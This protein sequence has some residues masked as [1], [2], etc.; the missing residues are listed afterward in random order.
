MLTL[1]SLLVPFGLDLQK[2]VRLVRHQDRRYDVT[3]LYRAG[4]LDFYQSIQSEAAF[5]DAETLVV[6]IGEAGTHALFVGVY[7]VR[8]VSRGERHKIP[9][10]FM[11][12]EMPTEGH[13]K[14]DLRLDT[15]FQE[16]VGRVVIDWGKGTRKWVQHFKHKD[17]IEV[18][19]RGYVRGFPG[20]LDVLLTYDELVRIVQHPASHREWHLRLGSMAGI[21]LIV[22]TVTGR[23]YVG[24]A[25][26]RAGL[27]G[28]WTDYSRTGHGGNKQLKQLVTARPGA[29]KDFQFAI[30]QTLPTTLTAKEVVAYEKL[31]KQKL[32][33]RAHGLNSN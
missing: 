28:R 16:L 14:Y 19:P 18:L 4:Q 24:S 25:Y 6:F 9:A 22:D 29:E 26:G 23:Q 32:G 7:A 33:S 21:Y 3:R 27:L 2:K 12:P 5:G 20:F 15:R 1:E 30:L 10:G 17:V 11:Y 31:H 8:S 13:F